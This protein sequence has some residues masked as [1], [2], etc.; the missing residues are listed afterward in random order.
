M[1]FLGVTELPSCLK[2]FMR[3][4]DVGLVYPM[5]GFTVVSSR[6]VEIHRDSAG[7]L[8]RDG[9]MAI[10]YADG[11]GFWSLHGVPVPQAIAETRAEELDPKLALSEPN[12]EVRREI[13]R[14]VGIERFIQAAGAK[15]LDSFRDYEL[16]SVRLSD[17]A[18]DCRYLKMVNPSIGVWHVEGVDPQ[19]RTVRE[20]LHFRKPDALRRIPISESGEDWFQQGD[21]CCWPRGSASVKPLPA[22]IT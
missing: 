10:K 8:H 16:L 12:T 5:K 1:E 13:I 21:V 20:A 22:Q 15:V 11:W 7:R 3:L 6:P 14:K 4:I 9:G 17:D 19:C 2:A 18:P